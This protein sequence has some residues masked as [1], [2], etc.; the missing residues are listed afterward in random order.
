MIKKILSFFGFQDK[1]FGAARS[2]KWNKIRK[3]HLKIRPFCEA[4]GKKGKLLKSNEIHHCR[5]FHLFPEDEL[6][7]ENLITLCREHHYLFG[8]LNSWSSYNVSVKDDSKLWYNKIK[9]RPI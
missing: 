1:T 8:H 6:K 3:R 5:P 9:T 7:F 4:C 2:P